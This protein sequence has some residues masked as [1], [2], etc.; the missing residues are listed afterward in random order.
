MFKKVYYHLV[1]L[2]LLGITILVS[3]CGGGGNSSIVPGTVTDPGTNPNSVNNTIPTPT[4]ILVT[5][6]AEGYLFVTNSMIEDG[7]KIENLNVLDVPAN[8]PDE[9]GN[10][11]FIQ[12]VAD[13]LKEDP[14]VWNSPQIQELYNALNVSLSQSQPLPVYASN[15]NVYSSYQDSQSATPIPVNADGS[16]NSQVLTGASDSTV[17]LEVSIDDDTYLDVETVTGGDI[18]SSGND[19][20][21]GLKSCPSKIIVMPGDVVEFKVYTYPKTNLKNLGLIFTLNDSSLGTVSPPVYLRKDGEKNYTQAEGCFHAKKGL[22]TPVNTTITVKTNNGL[23][24]DIPVEIVKATALISGHVYTGGYPLVKGYVK[25]Y[26]PKSCCKL[27]TNGD[28][29]LKKVFL[30]HNVK[31][32][33]TWWTLENGQK[34][35]HREEKIIDFFNSDVTGFNFGVIPTPTLTA[36][37]TPT[38]TP[39]ATPTPRLPTDPYF[40]EIVEKVINQKFQWEES[41]GLELAVEKTVKWLSGEVIDPP[42]PYE[43]SE[44]ITKAE[45]DSYDS[46]AMRIYFKDGVIYYFPN[47]D[48]IKHVLEAGENVNYSQNRNEPKSTLLP[49]I[50]ANSTNNM[51]ET[52]KNPK[53]LVLSPFTW[54][55]LYSFHGQGVGKY[56]VNWFLSKLKTFPYYADGKFLEIRVSDTLD[57]PLSEAPITLVKQYDLFGRI[58]PEILCKLKSGYED[59]VIRLQD[60]ENLGDYG[61]IYIDTH[62]DTSGLYC[63]PYYINDEGKVDDKLDKWL[64]DPKNNGLW[65][66]VTLQPNPV[67][68]LYFLSDATNVDVHFKC[69]YLKKEFFDKQQNFDGSLVFIN[70][71]ESYFFHLYGGFSNARVYLG[72]NV[73]SRAAWSSSLAFYYF[74]CMTTGYIPLDKLGQDLSPD[75]ATTLAVR[76][77]IILFPEPPSDRP[78]SVIQAYNILQKIGANPNTQDDDYKIGGV[79]E[80]KL[81]IDTHGGE[82]ENVYFPTSE[83]ITIHKN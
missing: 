37:A 51:A 26:G 50:I 32:R 47:K 7:D 46:K 5:K 17:N 65:E 27:D 56:T 76:P 78:M 33:T 8:K 18:N 60:F 39:S 44:A 83:E 58:K 67:M 22:S 40:D 59:K 70:A 21:A 54:Q 13:T 12:Q 68:Y 14:Q 72:H 64:N 48:K 63:C 38:F 19:T 36:T 35:R 23:K 16:F 28:Y 15:A 6:P 52:V 55:L 9:A 74:Y 10:Q 29:T 20:T 3:N 77:Y 2:V 82:H 45:I 1:I 61:I 34:V 75:M 80:S 4:P 53:I 79:L 42:V 49:H 30:A 24:L 81:F 71:C 62:G 43:I 11:P 73:D 57:N 41:L 31:V 69:I 25:S 66:Y